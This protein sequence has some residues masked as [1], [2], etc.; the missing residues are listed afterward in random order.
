MV[1]GAVITGVLVN[2]NDPEADALVRKSGL[3]PYNL[4]LLKD[5]QITT[6][7]GE[8]LSAPVFAVAKTAVTGFGIQDGADALGEQEIAAATPMLVIGRSE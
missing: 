8:Q 4:V 7:S 6:T 5:A 2:R 1:D 3:V